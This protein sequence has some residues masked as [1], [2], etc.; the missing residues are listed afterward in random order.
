MDPSNNLW[1]IFNCNAW[2]KYRRAILKKKKK[3]PFFEFHFKKRPPLFF[4]PQK[5][6]KFCPCQQTRCKLGRFYN[7][8]QIYESSR[9]PTPSSS[10]ILDPWWATP[11][12]NSTTL[13][14]WGCQCRIPV[15]FNSEPRVAN[16]LYNFFQLR[17]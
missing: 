12:S 13:R 11:G 16:Y 7:F 1:N 4:F 17:T 10:I 9:L 2:Y 8:W 5:T 15:K 3:N 14:T 6:T